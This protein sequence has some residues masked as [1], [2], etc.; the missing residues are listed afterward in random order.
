MSSHVKQ[1]N[2]VPSPKDPATL[3]LL[4]MAAEHQARVGARIREA[5]KAK[6]WT[7]AQLARAMPGSVESASV[8]R[9]ERG[10]VM[11]RTDTLDA[12]AQALDVDAAY[13]LVA[14][15]KNGT[16]PLMDALRRAQDDQMAT[17]LDRIETMVRDLAETVAEVAAQNTAA[18][19]AAAAPSPP[20]AAPDTD[21]PG[22]APARP[23]DAGR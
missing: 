4:L 2:G 9:W 12:P 8:S 6:D 17:R 16:P 19:A 15:P 11:P 1:Q 10:Q 18:I 20:A 23:G 13:F 14:A 3:R 7:Q 22:H 21:A 5:R